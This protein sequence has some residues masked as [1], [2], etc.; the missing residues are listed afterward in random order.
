MDDVLE[1]EDKVLEDVAEDE[2]FV[3]SISKYS[4]TTTARTWTP[5]I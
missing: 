1:Y 3:A 5:T 4:R 2:D